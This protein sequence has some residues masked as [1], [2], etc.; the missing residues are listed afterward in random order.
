MTEKDPFETERK[1]ATPRRNPGSIPSQPAGAYA[2][3]YEDGRR[4][5][6]A[7]DRPDAALERVRARYLACVEAA[8][9]TPADQAYLA[10]VRDAAADNLPSPPSEPYR[11][12]A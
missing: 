11:R 12:A 9:P 6:Q 8:R 1:P 2:L 4:L 3:G 7:Q 10:G 5:L